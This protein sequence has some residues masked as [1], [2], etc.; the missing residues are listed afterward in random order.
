MMIQKLA[1]DSKFFLKKIARIS[2]LHKTSIEKLRSSIETLF[3]KGSEC[4][5]VEIPKNK[6]SLIKYCNKQN[7][8]LAD[9]KLILKKDKLTNRNNLEN[10]KEF[11]SKKSL[12]QIFDITDEISLVS[13]FHKDPKFRPLA[14][15]LYRQWVENAIFHHYCDKYFIYFE[16]HSPLGIIILKSKNK[17]MF[18][19]L[20]GVH[21]DFRRKGIGTNLITKAESWTRGNNFNSLYVPTQLNNKIALK[22]YRKTGF[23]NF[24]EIYIYHIWKEKYETYTIQ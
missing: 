2:V 5:Y 4:I 9:K 7:F 12:S 13:R 24:E 6:Q 14:K 1:W 17:K 19:D 16:K 11:I 10:I 18:I 23:R 3:N 22:T 15:N 20:F 21:K 8:F